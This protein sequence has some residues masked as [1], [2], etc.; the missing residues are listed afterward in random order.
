M[1]SG[2]GRYSSVHVRVECRDCGHAWDGASVNEYGQ[3]W[4][5]PHEECPSCGSGELDVSDLDALDIE[6]RRLE[7]RGEDF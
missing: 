5:E 6:E 3:G 2:P 4:L 7:A 1:G